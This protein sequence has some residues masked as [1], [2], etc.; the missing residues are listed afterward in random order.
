MT[1]QPPPPRADLALNSS[2][3]RVSLSGDWVLAT[4]SGLYAQASAARPA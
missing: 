1:A 4:A 2:G 3:D